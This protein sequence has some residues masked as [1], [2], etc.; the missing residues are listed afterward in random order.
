MQLMPDTAR[1]LGVSNAYDPEQN[2]MAGTR[3]LKGLLNGTT[4][5]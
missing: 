3:Y 5:M 2:V 1:G 4:G